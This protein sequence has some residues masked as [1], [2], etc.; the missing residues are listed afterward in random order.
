[1]GADGGAG[2]SMVA[3]NLPMFDVNLAFALLQ[4]SAIIYERFVPLFPKG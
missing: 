3:E 4:M 1:M 2:G